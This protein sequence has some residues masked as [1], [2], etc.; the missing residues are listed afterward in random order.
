MKIIIS[1]SQYY[2]LRRMSYMNDSINRQLDNFKHNFFDPKDCEK[3]K[4]EDFLE[5]IK[6][7]LL[8]DLE[9]DH[10]ELSNKISMVDKFIENH[11]K[12]EIYKSYCEMCN[13]NCADINNLYDF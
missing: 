5:N 8:K 7:H 3:M 6:F 13:L 12:Q 10:P 9:R 11:K 2:L 1:E 4:F